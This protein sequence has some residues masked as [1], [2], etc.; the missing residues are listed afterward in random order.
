[1]DAIVCLLGNLKTNLSRGYI[2]N[3]RKILENFIYFL[4]VSGLSCGTRDLRC[5]MQDLSLKGWL[6][7]T[8]HGLLF[9]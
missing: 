4:A 7:V 5:G 3:W 8:A 1:M 9:S 6:F 2:F